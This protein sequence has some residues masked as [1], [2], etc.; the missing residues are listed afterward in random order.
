MPKTSV[1]VQILAERIEAERVLRKQS[2]TSLALALG[3]QSEEYA[4]RLDELNHVHEQAIKEQARTV[5]REMFDTYIK[6][7]D[8]KLL[9]ATRGLD[10]KFRVLNDRAATFITQEADNRR[11]GAVEKDV[12]DLKTALRDYLTRDA[13]DRQT[14]AV[15]SEM[16]GIRADVKAALTV[17]RFDREHKTLADK[18]EVQL[19]GLRDSL[20]VQERVTLRQDTQ[21]ELL[22]KMGQS[23]RWQVGIGVGL[24]GIALS[25]GLSLLALLLHLAGAY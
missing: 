9:L 13:Y 7:S 17:E 14:A 10:D 21:S 12:A 2:E 8:A 1:S 25:S 5:P 15:R 19:T 6:E 11:M 18:M 16:D 4:R 23:H 22:D 20:S 24:I 3:V